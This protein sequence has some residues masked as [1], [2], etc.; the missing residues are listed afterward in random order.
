MPNRL[1]SAPFLSLY[2]AAAGALALNFTRDRYGSQPWFIMAASAVFVLGIAGVRGVLTH[3]RAATAAPPSPHPAR[4]WARIVLC[5]CFAIALPAVA[6]PSLGR[7]AGRFIAI[8]LALSAA[9]AA[10]ALLSFVKLRRH[11]AAAPLTNRC[12]ICRYDLT[13]NTTGVCPECGTP[14]TMSPR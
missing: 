4:I 5:V 3:R 11:R 6:L 10:V 2:L 9:F 13:G 12:P 7:E 8:I 14:V 1:V